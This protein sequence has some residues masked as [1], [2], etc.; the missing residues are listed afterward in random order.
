MDQLS[1]SPN[2]S[3]A[4]ALAFINLPFCLIALIGLPFLLYILGSETLNGE[5][6]KFRS[7]FCHAIWLLLLCY[8][9]YLEY[10]YFQIAYR[11]LSPG[12][13]RDIWMHS[14]LFNGF[15]LFYWL[16]YYFLQKANRVGENV[17]G[18][19]L[20]FFILFSLIYGYLSFKALRKIELPTPV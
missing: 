3:L 8:G 14:L 12:R 9:L 10:G 4:K 18:F 7:F 11:D 19:L 16:L 13:E 20:L 2:E 6:L 17:N 1:H 5:I 15:A